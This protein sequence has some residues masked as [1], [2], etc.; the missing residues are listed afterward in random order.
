MG[1][2]VKMLDLSVGGQVDAE[3]ILREG[4]RFRVRLAERDGHGAN[5]ARVLGRSSAQGDHGPGAGE[6]A[7]S[8]RRLGGVLE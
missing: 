3:G 7:G 1:G 5:L 2:A 8:L 4:T 6:W